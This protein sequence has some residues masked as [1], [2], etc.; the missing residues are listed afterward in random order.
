MISLRLTCP[1]CRRVEEYSSGSRSWSHSH[2]ALKSWV[3]KKESTFIFW[4]VAL[5][6]MVLDSGV[7]G[8]ATCVLNEY[9][10]SNAQQST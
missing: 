2:A 10:R 3:R 6:P 4:H 7:R 9:A 8:L 1:V 5:S